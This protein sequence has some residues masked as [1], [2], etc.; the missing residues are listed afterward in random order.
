MFLSQMLRC[1]GM[2]SVA[3]RL[4]WALFSTVDRILLVKHWFCVRTWRNM[5]RAGSLMLRRGPCGCFIELCAVAGA[6]LALITV[7]AMLVS[8]RWDTLVWLP[9][10]CSPFHW[11]QILDRIRLEGPKKCWRSCC[12]HDGF[13]MAQPCDHRPSVSRGI[14]SRA[15]GREKWDFPCFP[16][17]I[18]TDL[19]C[20]R[21]CFTVAERISTVAR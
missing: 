21:T 19:K 1:W 10:C 5:S 13:V 18:W 17:F 9:N 7:I 11:G 4:D 12:V 3:C 20:G 14:T 6:T 16:N 15:L 8:S 2:T